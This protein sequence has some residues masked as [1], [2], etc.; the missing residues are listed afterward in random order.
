MEQQG[1]EGMR[2]DNSGSTIMFDHHTGKTTQ[3]EFQLEIMRLP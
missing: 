2:E 3:V 1:E